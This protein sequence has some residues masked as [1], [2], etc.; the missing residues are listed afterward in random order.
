MGRSIN[1]SLQV[2]REQDLG[3]GG[4]GLQRRAPLPRGRHAP[5]QQ[6]SRLEA[7][8]LQIRYRIFRNT[9]QLFLLNT[10]QLFLRNTKQLFLPNTKQL[11][12][13]ILVVRCV[14]NI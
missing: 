12:F 4:P 5:Q 11:I 13:I 14:D 10:K 1:S 7:E 3:G 6:D 2:P 8:G 9:K